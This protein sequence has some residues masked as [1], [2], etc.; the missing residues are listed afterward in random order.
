MIGFRNGR[1]PCAS[2]VIQPF[3]L[4]GNQDVRVFHLKDWLII[5]GVVSYVI[6]RRICSLIVK[7][8]AEKSLASH[9]FKY[10][11]RLEEG[12]DAHRPDL[13]PEVMFI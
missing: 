8:S 7:E 1:G 11:S 4:L 12:I 3:F 6:C 9:L 13:R 5:L 2:F 10:G